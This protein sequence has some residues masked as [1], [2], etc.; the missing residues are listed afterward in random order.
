MKKAQNEM[1][2]FVLI[3]V[4]VIFILAIFLFISL[5]SPKEGITDVKAGNLLSSLLKYT[6]NCA[7]VYEPQYDDLSALIRSCSDNRRCSNLDKDACVYLNETLKEIMENVLKSEAE[8]KDYDLN[9]SYEKND[10]YARQ[11]N[12]SGKI[13]GAQEIISTGIGKIIVKIRFCY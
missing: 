9:I 13:T 6:T 7:I 12:C 4:L 3:V 8:I 11:G 5:K 10:L 1:V 2:G